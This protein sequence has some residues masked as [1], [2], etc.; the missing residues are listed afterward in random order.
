V[1]ARNYI[2]DKLRDKFPYKYPFWVDFPEEGDFPA[3]E[4]N[5]IEAEV[6]AWKVADDGFLEEVPV[7]GWVDGRPVTEGDAVLYIGGT[8][9][10]SAMPMAGDLVAIGPAAN[11]HGCAN[12]TILK[13]NDGGETATVVTAQ[14]CHS[15][16][17][18]G[19]DRDY[20]FATVGEVIPL[21]DVIPAGDRWSADVRWEA[22]TF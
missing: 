11:T 5:M 9:A 13:I 14:S 16:W 20:V 18:V 10:P 19:H 6:T 12:H 15:C 7:T 1:N 4:D 2:I 8:Q 17:Q 3:A 22:K 21:P